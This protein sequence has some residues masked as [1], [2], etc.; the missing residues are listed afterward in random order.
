MSGNH[1]EVELEQQPIELY[2]LL[3]IAD[4]VSGGGEAKVLISEGY[5]FLNDEV[6]TQKRKKIYH[7]DIVAFNGDI[8]ELICHQ[9]PQETTKQP[10]PRTSKAK[11]S[12]SKPQTGKKQNKSKKSPQSTDK[13]AEPQPNQGRRRSIKF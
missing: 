7:G 8:I 12:A 6:E 4:L 10:K 13:P 11:P 3:K 2:K 1:Y 9:P 5:V